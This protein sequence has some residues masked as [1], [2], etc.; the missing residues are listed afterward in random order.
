M[1]L[2]GSDCEASD[3]ALR[4]PPAALRPGARGYATMLRAATLRRR[5]VG[6]GQCRWFERPRK[7]I[8]PHTPSSDSSSCPC[9]CS[10]SCSCP[11]AGCWSCAGLLA[12]ALSS[13]TRRG[14]CL[15]GVVSAPRRW[16][17]FNEERE[18]NERKCAQQ[19]SATTNL[20]V[21]ERE[22]AG[23]ARHEKLLTACM[24]PLALIYSSALETQ[25]QVLRQ[26]ADRRAVVG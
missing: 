10:C 12:R 25:V 14:P 13:G 20:R 6:R 16:A 24:N 4:P 15:G 21:R 2:G 26:S 3:S 18:E 23:R 11:C 1:W 17:V 8:G 7:R 22:M 19:L 9:S 5:C